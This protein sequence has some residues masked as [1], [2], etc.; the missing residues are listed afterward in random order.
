LLPSSLWGKN[1][2]LSSEDKSQPTHVHCENK[3]N[4]I[5]ADKELVRYQSV[6]DRLS[7][8]ENPNDKEKEG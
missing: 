6:I 2:A 4:C 7:T 3:L 8:E 5:A 1:D